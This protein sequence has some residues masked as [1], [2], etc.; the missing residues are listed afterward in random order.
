[1]TTSQEEIL[2]AC[3]ILGKPH[4]LHFTA[5]PQ[6]G[7]TKEEIVEQISSHSHIPMGKISLK[8]QWWKQGST[9]LLVFEKNTQKP[10]VLLPTFSGKY[11]IFSAKKRR[12]KPLGKKEAAQIENKGFCFYPLLPKKVPGLKE[13]VL[14]VVKEKKK[15]MGMIAFL[16]LR[17]TL[18]ALLPL[19]AVQWVFNHVHDKGSAGLGWSLAI[20]LGIAAFGAAILIYLRNKRLLRLDGFFAHR[21][22]PMLWQRIFEFPAF[23]FKREAKLSIFQKIMGL[24]TIRQGAFHLAPQILFSSCFSLLYL[25]LMAIFS[26]PLTLISVPFLGWAFWHVY[27]L[28]HTK[29]RVKERIQKKEEESR[30]FLSESL[31]RM[32]NIRSWGQESTIYKRWETHLK[33]NLLRKRIIGN[34]QISLTLIYWALPLTILWLILGGITFDYDSSR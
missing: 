17:G 16:S 10:L 11:R 12:S 4:K 30:A 29:H 19:L 7:E 34:T 24:E 9:P 18:L 22:Q 32:T 6:V 1:M 13:L 28:I 8:N 31:S 14:S 5:P 23:F 33:Q 25:L 26:L 20:G 27:H 2:T 15:E 21:M 3:N